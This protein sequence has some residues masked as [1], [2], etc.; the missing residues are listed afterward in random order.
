MPAYQW[1]FKEWS[2]ELK[3]PNAGSCWVKDVSMPQ[4][5]HRFSPWPGIY[6]CAGAFPPPKKNGQMLQVNSDK[7]FGSK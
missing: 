2:C 1:F 6:T 5:W 7:C 4:L 3:W